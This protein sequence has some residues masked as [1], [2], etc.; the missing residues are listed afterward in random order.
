M[1]QIRTLIEPTY[2][3]R[4]RSLN[5]AEQIK[6]EISAIKGDYLWLSNFEELNDPMEGTY[7]ASPMLKKDSRFGN[8]KEHIYGQKSSIGICSF[9]ETNDQELMW[10]HYADQFRGVCIEYY[11]PRLLKALDKSIDFS[12]IFY[13]EKRYRVFPKSATDLDI[14]KKILCTKSH[15]WLYERE[16][17]L[18]STNTHRLNLGRGDCISQVYL[19]SR[20]RPEVKQTLVN[21]LS[22]KAI[23]YKTMSIDGYNISF[24]PS[25]RSRRAGASRT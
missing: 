16:W 2:L 24:E 3:Y 21:C 10:A 15:R 12:R 13:N 19:G 7:E 8:I 22:A 5:S 4:Y 25:G 23:R 18:F 6:N 14:A 11:L 17:R 9:S 1:A 20:M